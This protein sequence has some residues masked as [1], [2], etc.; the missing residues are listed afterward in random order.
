MHVQWAHAVVLLFLVLGQGGL[1][2]WRGD[3][4]LK[5]VR[6][7]CLFSFATRTY[8]FG[9]DGLPT[10]KIKADAIKAE[11]VRLE[12]TLEPSQI[13]CERMRQVGSPHAKL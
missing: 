1:A 7:Q 4:H 9:I 12:E 8:P 5:S 3:G 10:E 6:P 11:I 13:R 2:S